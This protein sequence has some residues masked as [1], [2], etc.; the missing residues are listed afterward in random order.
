MSVA[1]RDEER[2]R[3]SAIDDTVKKLRA[4]WN[5]PSRMR[6]DYDAGAAGTANA[7]NASMRLHNPAL[8]AELEEIEAERARIHSMLMGGQP[9]G[10]SA[11]DALAERAERLRL[12]FSSLMI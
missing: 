10:A 2:N 12:S 11:I 8:K 1:Q 7:A 5:D 6:R 3:I 4:R 9:V